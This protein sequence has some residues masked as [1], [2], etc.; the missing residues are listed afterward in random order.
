MPRR[1]GEVDRRIVDHRAAAQ[2]RDEA[3]HVHAAENQPARDHPD[4][5]GGVAPQPEVARTARM[6]VDGVDGHRDRGE[7]VARGLDH[8]LA[9]Q[10]ERARGAVRQV[11]LAEQRR[12]IGALPGLRVEHAMAGRPRDPEVGEAVGEA[13]RRRHRPVASHARADRERPRVCRERAQ[14]PRHVVDVVLAVAVHRDDH[15]GTGGKRGLH[16]VP[17][18]RRLAEV[19]LVT[20]ERHRHAGER[21]GRSVGRAVVDDDHDFR[22]RQGAQGDRADRRGLVERGNDDRE[23]HGAGFDQARF[24]ACR[25][26]RLRS[27][28]RRSFPSASSPRMRA[29]PRRDRDR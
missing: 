15:V 27:S 3:G 14:Q 4:D 7:A 28:R 25:A 21:R 12:G 16:A 11:D 5:A 24:N 13:S 18:A 8:E 9:F 1:R 26:W 22:E 19:A 29:W 10:R 17:Q 23:L 20:D 6:Q 2:A